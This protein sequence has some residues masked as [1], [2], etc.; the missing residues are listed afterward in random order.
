M[1]AE[2]TKI[3]QHTLF[4][5]KC[6]DLNGFELHVLLA[7]DGDFH[8]SVVPAMDNPHTEIYAACLSASMRV[9]MPMIGGGSH[10]ALYDGLRKAIAGELERKPVPVAVTDAPPAPMFYLLSLKHSMPRD[11]VLTWWGKNSHG[12]RWNLNDAGLFSE[13][14]A[15]D[16]MQRSLFNGVRTVVAVPQAKAEE[17]ACRNVSVDDFEKL[18]LSRDEWRKASRE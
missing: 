11:N 6:D 1:S 8:V 13:A 17:L 18:G 10:E 4:K 5:W 12:Y 15:N 14:E 9:R 3:E 2:I 16:I 7:G